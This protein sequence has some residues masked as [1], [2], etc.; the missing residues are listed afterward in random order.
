MSSKRLNS[1]STVNRV[2]GTI[3]VA[4]LAIAIGFT[5]GSNQQ[6]SAQT[7]PS[8]TATPVTGTPGPI[9]TVPIV[10]NPVVVPK[11]L[12]YVV[13]KQQLNSRIFQA[14]AY[15]T[16][17]SNFTSISVTCL[18]SM[19]ERNSDHRKFLLED[20]CPNSAKKP[21][22]DYV[23]LSSA[24]RR[25]FDAAGTLDLPYL[26]HVGSSL[27][28]GRGITARAVCDSRLPAIQL[29]VPGPLQFSSRVWLA[30]DGLLRVTHS[31]A[32]AGATIAHPAGNNG[33]GAVYS[34]FSDDPNRI[35]L[36]GMVDLREGD[37][38]SVYFSM[39]GLNAVPLPCARELF[40]ERATE[41]PSFSADGISGSF[42][43]WYSDQFGVTTNVTQ[44]AEITTELVPNGQTCFLLNLSA[45]YLGLTAPVVQFL[46]T[47]GQSCV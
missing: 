35:R 37:L 17:V 2:V 7:S 38:D 10:V 39:I 5:A 8:T 28:I 22:D 26:E 30:A 14:Q 47:F 13:P 33:Y 4:T 6:V 40:I 20:T 46:E 1:G 42:N 23:E 27:P 32:S 19:V 45:K 11:Y 3:L 43:V 25:T 36:A 34:G 44:L 15:M 18:G 41:E 12:T 16:Y 29:A 9:T 21:G 24:V 31:E